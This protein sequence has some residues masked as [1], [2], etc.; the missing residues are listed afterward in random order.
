MTYQFNIETTQNMREKHKP[1]IITN[2]R[3]THRA[4]LVY[5]HHHLII[6]PKPSDGIHNLQ[7]EYTQIGK[8]HN[9]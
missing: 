4:K 7:L 8:T 2:N 1:S 5:R 3:Y 6:S 9:F